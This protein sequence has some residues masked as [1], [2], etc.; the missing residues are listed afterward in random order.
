[1]LTYTLPEPKKS[2]DK[3]TCCEYDDY[4]W[5]R[6]SHFPVSKEM[7]EGVNVNDEVTIVLK[8][9]VFST[10]ARSSQSKDAVNEF[11]ELGL[12]ISTIELDVPNEFEKLAED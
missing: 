7:V 1:M 8:G 3:D 6:R 10:E 4:S 12:E 2:D 11:N 5:R 9:K